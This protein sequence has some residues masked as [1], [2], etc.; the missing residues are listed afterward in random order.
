[1]LAQLPLACLLLIAAAA[2]LVFCFAMD[3]WMKVRKLTVAF[4]VISAGC[5]LGMIAVGS[6][7]HQHWNARQML[8]LYS[9]AWGGLTIGMFPSRKLFLKYGDEMRRGVKREKYEYPARCQAA[10]YASVILMCFLA[11]VLAT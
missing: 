2:T 8:V 4:L 3:R 7:Q 6:L 9:F 5:C 11:F 10:L 1:M